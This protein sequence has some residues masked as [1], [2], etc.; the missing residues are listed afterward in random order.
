[1]KSIYFILGLLVSLTQLSHAHGADENQLKDE[2]SV[3]THAV[4]LRDHVI[5]AFDAYEDGK[6]LPDCLGILSTL[7]R[8]Q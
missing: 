6:P 4:T 8:W 2:G 1:M 3:R 5:D 7:C